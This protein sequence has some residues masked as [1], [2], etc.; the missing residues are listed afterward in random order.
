MADSI[1]KTSETGQ[2][3]LSLEY[4]GSLAELKS[5]YLLN[6]RQMKSSW[7]EQIRKIM[8]QHGYT[9]Q[10]LAT[11]C[12]V[13]RSGVVRWLE[14]SL[15]SSRD[16]F[17]RIGFAA[18]YNLQEMNR[19][20]QR[21]GRYNKLYAKSLEDSVYIFVLNSET[22]PH[23]YAVCQELLERLRSRLHRSEDTLEGETGRLSQALLS[24][25]TSDELEQF[26]QGNLSQ[27]RTVFAKFYNRVEEHIEALNWSCG[28]D[29]GG[30]GLRPPFSVS[31][32][33][34]T[35]GWSAS[36]RRS[37]SEIRQRK[38]FPR[39]TKIISL[40][41]HLNLNREKIDELLELAYMEPLCAKNPVEGAIIFAVLDAEVCD[42][43]PPPEM[44][45]ASTGLC[46]YVR[47]VLEQLELPDAGDLIQ[48]LLV[49]W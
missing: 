6:V 1:S 34:D 15:P 39:R 22:L 49:E 25:E 20:L 36:L 44:R 2:L 41:L 30:A 33:A 12:G 24:L 17:I 9:P 13:S 4:I 14:G 43:I 42:L 35:Q 18:G 28:L 29:R 19:F 47:E 21:Y 11:L 38:W 40:G 23:T 7:S 46:D 26:I 16:I 8:D 32:L 31:R 10:T 45:D 27:Y 5:Q 48:D 37:V 3:S